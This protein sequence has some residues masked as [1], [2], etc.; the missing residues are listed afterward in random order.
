MAKMVIQIDD[1]ETLQY[2]FW[3][4]GCEACHFVRLKGPGANWQM[5]G[6]DTD[7]PTVS[8]S[9]LVRRGDESTRCHSFVKGGMIQYLNDCAHSLKGK[10]VEIPDF[11]S[12]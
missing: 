10:T 7:T 2:M 4:P 3:C 11:E 8:P 12:I 1:G 5:T 9:L 6:L